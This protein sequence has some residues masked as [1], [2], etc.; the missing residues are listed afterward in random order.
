MEI[1]IKLYALSY[2]VIEKTVSQKLGNGAKKILSKALHFQKTYHPI[3]DSLVTPKG[4]LNLGDLKSSVTR[5][6]KRVRFHKLMGGLNALL[7]EYLKSVSLTLGKNLTR[8]II[9]QIRKESAQIIAQER[10]IA[11][12]YELEEELLRALKIF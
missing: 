1:V 4:F 6:P 2:Q 9:A 7:S 12:E 5:I 11:K 10:E 8:Q 3:L